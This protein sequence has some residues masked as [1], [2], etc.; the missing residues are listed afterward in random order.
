MIEALAYLGGA[1]VLVGA[2]LI[3]AQYWPD[4]GTGTRL[5]IVATTALVLLAAGFAVPAGTGAV[6]RRLRAILWLLSTAA[7]AAFWA[8][9]GDQSLL[10]GAEDTALLTGLATT[11]YAA[12]LWAVS[13]TALQQVATF[14]GTLITAGTAGAQLAG[15]SWPGIAIWVTSLAWLVAGRA[16]VLA[17]KRLTQA[18]AAAGLVLGA[19]MTMPADGGIVFALATTIALI[20][21][22]VIWR[23]IV[24]VLI[25]AIGLVQVLPMAV[26]TWFSGRAA[27]PM[28]LVLGGGLL[29]VAAVVLAR[30][31]ADNHARPVIDPERYD[32]V[33]F[34]LDVV[35][36][37]TPVLVERLR[38][39]QVDCAVISA[40]RE[41]A[42]V[43]RVAGLADTFQVR[44]DGVTADELALPGKPDP[45]M[46]LLAARRLG[47]QPRR[48]VLVE[49][50]PAGVAAGSAGAFG[51]V[52]G[53]DHSGQP[54]DLL[55]A[56]ADVVIR[57]LD[58]LA[59]PTEQVSVR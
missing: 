48:T 41:C 5:I 20:C 49:N 35:T 43:L 54:D 52:V 1:V 46:H 18:A 24:V 26:T 40:R 4:L 15:D 11:M 25:G 30:R 51:L 57:D 58:E 55:S 47:V 53:V 16:G 32:A 28:A 10:W 8:L 19:D 13:Q 2:M 38:A 29:V 36:D 44:V 31:T 17:S 39:A 27:A 3:G 21:A 42:E 12:A 56:G 34:D 50:T 45:A 23:E 37:T 33:L 14:A 7:G 22:G 9:L 59:V 6:P